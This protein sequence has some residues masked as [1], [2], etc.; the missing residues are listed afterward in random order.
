MVRSHEERFWKFVHPEPNT[1]C[2]LWGG[3]LMKTGYGSFM[4]PGKEPGAKNWRARYAHRF[5]WELVHGPVPDGMYVC[6]TCDVRAC[7]NVDHLFL[8]TPK[9]NTHDAMRKGRH[10]KGETQGHSK[11]TEVQVEEIRRNLESDTAA[12]T[13]YGVTRQ[14]INDVRNGKSWRHLLVS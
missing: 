1:G 10:I 6:H 9:D 2:F 11:L 4:M 8:G 3:A 14:A 5:A 12:A 7:V 13:R